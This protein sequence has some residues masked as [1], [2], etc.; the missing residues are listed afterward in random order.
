MRFHRAGDS[1]T[2]D[3]TYSYYLTRSLPDTEVLNLGVSGYGHDQMLLY[4]K[5][6]GAKYHPD[7]VI[8]GYVSLD[9][10]RNLLS[11]RDLPNRNSNS[12]ET[13]CSPRMFPCPRRHRCWP[14]N[15][16]D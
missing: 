10:P 2:H 13:A 4:L 9:A 8:L 6:E 11:F 7:V 16:F 12:Q 15:P 5:E 14:G 3:K 1:A